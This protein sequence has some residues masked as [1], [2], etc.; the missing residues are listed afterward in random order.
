[1]EK[2]TGFWAQPPVLTSFIFLIA[3]DCAS[4]MKT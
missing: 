4:V 2:Q 1:V 3:L